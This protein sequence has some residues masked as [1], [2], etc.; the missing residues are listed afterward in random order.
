MAEP[1]DRGFYISGLGAG[2]INGP[3]RAPGTNIRLEYGRLALDQFNPMWVVNPAEKLFDLLLYSGKSRQDFIY[4]T[5]LNPR[6]PNW[7]ARWNA[8]PIPATPEVKK[9]F[10][11][12]LPLY[13]TW[14]DKWRDSVQPAIDSAMARAGLTLEDAARFRAE[15]DKNRALGKD[16]KIYNEKFAYVLMANINQDE[17]PKDNIRIEGIESILENIPLTPAGRL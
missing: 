16:T 4:V 3:L 10:D 1:T 9:V 11:H 7:D 17:V 15:D 6:T 5:R 14:R 8:V 12:Y 13:E 2:G